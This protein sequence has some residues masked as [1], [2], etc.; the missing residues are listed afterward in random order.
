VYVP[1]G[2][3]LISAQTQMK[4]IG[5]VDP[6]NIQSGTELGKQW[7]GTYISVEPLTTGVLSFTYRLP[8]S[9]TKQIEDGLYTLLVQKQIGLVG[10]SLTLDLDFDTTI[11]TANPP[12]AESEWGNNSYKIE[13]PLESDQGFEMRF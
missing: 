10:A 4:S 8:D 11:T 1:N 13:M 5:A 12:E 9:I 6:K 3:I 2:S 7:F